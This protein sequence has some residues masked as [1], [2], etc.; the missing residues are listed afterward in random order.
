MRV[1]KDLNNV[2]KSR[3]LQHYEKAKAKLTKM[4]LDNMMVMKCKT[5]ACEI[6]DRIIDMEMNV[7]VRKATQNLKTLM[8]NH[9]DIKS[10]A[11]NTN[12]H[13]DLVKNMQAFRRGVAT[14]KDLQVYDVDT[15]IQQTRQLI[16]ERDIFEHLSDTSAEVVFAEMSLFDNG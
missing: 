2:N 4:N 6:L 7:R 1:S 9:E 10:S 14:G 5:L 11:T 3:N 13:I 12:T 8:N 16:N 15:W